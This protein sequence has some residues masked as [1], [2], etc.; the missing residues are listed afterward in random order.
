[1]SFDRL[2]ADLEEAQRLLAGGD[3][4]GALQRLETLPQPILDEELAVEAVV[5]RG[6]ALCELD[7]TFEALEHVEQ[8]LAQYPESARLR[9]ALGAVLSSRGELEAAQR[10]LEQAALADGEDEMILSN[11]AMVYHRLED[12]A[13][14]IRTY[15]RL[16]SLGADLDA[17]LPR[18][19]AAQADA[20]DRDG[21]KRTLRRYLSLDPSDSGEWIALA[22][23]H[24]DDEEYEAAVECYQ[25]AE[26]LDADS[27][28]LRLNWGVTALRAGDLP[29]AQTQ[30]AHLRRV[31]SGGARGQL[32]E[33]FL[34]EESGEDDAAQALYDQALQSAQP[35]DP[36]ELHFVLNSAMEFYAR[37]HQSR[38]CEAVLERAYRCNAC[39]PDVCE[40]F[41]EATGD[42]VRDAACYA[43]VIE[44]N[45]RSGL[46]EVPEAGQG[47]RGPFTRFQRGFQFVA[48]DRDEAVA[49]GISF[50]R[51][52]GEQGVRVL[53]V[54]EQ[55]PLNDTFT[56]P[57]AVDREALVFRDD[58]SGASS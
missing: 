27:A 31:D 16:I 38:R 18:K 37:R 50:A 9:G 28:P 22:V 36:D 30:L 35:G 53:E 19:A 44:A 33:A 6:W 5:L 3:A 42:A 40:V 25:Q 52:M 34:R 1:M 7:R 24:S 17:V 23:M 26:A 20:G 57:F 51:R 55:E 13:R 41:R 15:D 58:V 21:A 2:Q 32:L 8:G 45:Y 10:E 4:Q 47:G 43:V 54:V 46:A 48:R 39:S 49:C 14:S 56:G 11:L 12:Y 29:A